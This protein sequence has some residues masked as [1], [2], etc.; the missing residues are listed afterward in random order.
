MLKRAAIGLRQKALDLARSRFKQGDAAQLDVA[1]A[2]PSWPQQVRSIG[3]EKRRAELEHAIALLVGRTPS[4]FS[5][6]APCRGGKPPLSPR[7]SLRIC[8]NAVLTLQ[9]RSGKWR[10]RTPGSVSPMRRCTRV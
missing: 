10:R 6:P 8:W 5:L 4:D 1:Q 7:P 9:R 2:G 3:L